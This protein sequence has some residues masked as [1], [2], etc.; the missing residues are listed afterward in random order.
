MKTDVKIRVEKKNIQLKKN[1]IKCITF[2]I[3]IFS[4]WLSWGWKDE[5]KC[6]NLKRFYFFIGELKKRA[7][8]WITTKFEVLRIRKCFVF[9]TR[10]LFTKFLRQISLWR[11]QNVFREKLTGI[12]T[13]AHYIWWLVEVKWL[14]YW[15]IRKIQI[16]FTYKILIPNIHNFTSFY[17]WTLAT[18]QHSP[19][20]LTIFIIMKQDETYFNTDL[21][22][23]NQI[24]SYMLV[25]FWKIWYLWFMEQCN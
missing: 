14:W 1:K 18:A 10:L 5:F 4:W 24:I 15:F 13:N 7:N 25:N 17:Q 12:N 9:F 16:T 11:N 20:A 21:F 3:W 23:L 6:K 2:S 19:S 8:V 22:F